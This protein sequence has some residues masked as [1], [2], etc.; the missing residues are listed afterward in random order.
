MEI[1]MFFGRNISIFALVIGLIMCVP[2]LNNLVLAL[3]TIGGS[4][5]LGYILQRIFSRFEEALRQERIHLM[6]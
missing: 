6:D 2:H 1:L 4:L 5:L 3:G